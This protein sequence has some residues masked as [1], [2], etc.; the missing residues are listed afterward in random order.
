MIMFKRALSA[1][2]LCCAT[3]APALVQAQNYS[4]IWWNPNE[5]GWGITL[6]DHQTQ[7]FG[8]WYTYDAD[9]K[10]TWFVIPGGT[11]SQGKRLFTGD[12][13]QTTGTPY[14]APFDA[15][16][17]VATKVGTASFDFAPPGLPAGTALYTYTVGTLTQTKQIE[18]QPFG[19]AGPSWGY[20][21]TDIWWDPAQSGWGLTL[22]QHGNNVFGVWFTYDVTGHPLWVVLPGVVFQNSSSFCGTLYTTT[23]PF[24][25]LPFDPR[26]VVV[27]EAGD[28][29]L[30]FTAGGGGGSFAPNLGGF[31]QTK[32]IT[33]QPFGDPPPTGA[34]RWIGTATGANLDVVTTASVTWTL[35]HQ[36]GAVATYKSSGTASSVVT[37]GGCPGG[38]SFNPP[39][40]DIDL[41]ASAPYNTVAYLTIDYSSVPP[42]YRG[43][44]FT[45]WEATLNC[46]GLAVPNIGGGLW[47]GG[48][49]GPFGQ[50]AAGSLSVD[51][52]TIE[53]TSADTQVPP[54][55]YNWKFIRSP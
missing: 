3:W 23:G 42:T 7:L 53:G 2:L 43:Y 51:G 34:P 25:T 19:N 40:H 21:Y 45:S 33:R 6:A 39:S 32:S 47:F 44:A 52:L 37:M 46:A 9:G 36:V 1:L 17:V 49:T 4:D 48:S 29:C 28:A 15:S 24:F 11:F 50:E 38:F 27:S 18:R 30:S 22:S 10:P 54:A 26:K 12:M 5:S 14:N 16:N 13:Y 35:D 31:A 41:S 55:T 20:D 8:V